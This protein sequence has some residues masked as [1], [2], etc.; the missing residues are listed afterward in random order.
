MLITDGLSN[1]MEATLA[2]AKLNR[3]ADVSMLVIGVLQQYDRPFDELRGLASWP[4]TNNIWSVETFRGLR[5]IRRDLRAA[6]CNGKP[7]K[8]FHFHVA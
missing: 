1:D 5:F 4:P 3:D 6:I 2:E 8:L 7:L